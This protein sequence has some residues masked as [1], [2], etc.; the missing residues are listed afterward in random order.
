MLNL[1]F[2]CDLL[3][4][5]QIFMTDSLQVPWGKDETFLKY[6]KFNA[7]YLLELF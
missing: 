1:S 2:Y 5:L 7:Y 4:S 3:Q 6:L